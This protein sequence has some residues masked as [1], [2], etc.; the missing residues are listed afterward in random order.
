M[1]GKLHL[2]PVLKCVQWAAIAQEL[3]HMGE[4]HIVAERV[5]GLMEIIGPS[6][7]ASAIAFLAARSTSRVV[8]GP[9]V[10]M[11]M[12]QPCGRPLMRPDKAPPEWLAM[13]PSDGQ[14]NNKF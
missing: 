14:R 1:L 8:S 5:A 2:K 3:L 11:T 7:T 9:M 13:L 12:A 10:H 4:G 6:L